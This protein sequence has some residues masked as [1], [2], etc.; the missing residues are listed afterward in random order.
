M[1]E[2]A[3][4]AVLQASWAVIGMSIAYIC[5]LLGMVFAWV[6]YRKRRSEESHQ[7]RK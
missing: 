6:Y 4:E 5:G 3:R 2:T 7:N 1:D